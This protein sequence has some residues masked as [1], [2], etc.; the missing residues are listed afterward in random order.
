MA[1]KNV[2]ILLKLE[3]KFTKP[4]KNASKE[5][6][7]QH[8][9]MM[10]LNSGVYSFSR[11]VRSGFTSALGHVARFG[12]AL[13]GIG[14]ILSVAGIKS[15]CEDAIEGFNAA[16]EAETKLEAVLGNVPSII[17]QGEGAAAAAKD[18]LVAYA[19]QLEEVGVVAGDVTTAGLQQ[20]ATF[21]LTEDSLKKLM[22]GMA[23]LIA[24][25]KGINATQ[26]DA[27]G[28]A[29]LMGKAMSGQTGALTR[30]GII[31]TEHQA[32]VMKTGNEMERA[33]M[34]AEILEANVGGVNEA[35]AQT[36][37]GKIVQAQNLLGRAQDEIGGKLMSLKAEIYGFAAQ[38]IPA[39]Q[40]AAM[41]LIDM[42]TPKIKAAMQWIADHT[43]DIKAGL[44][45][46]KEGVATAWG[47]IQP[48]LGFAI[49][50]AN[51]LIPAILGVVGAISGV[52]V[53]A[54]VATKV[55]GLVK[56]FQDMRKVVKD[57]GGMLA[58]LKTGPIALI[59]LGIAAA[60]AAVIYLWNHCEGFRNF[61]KKAAAVIV[62]AWNKIKDTAVKVKD[63]A[64]AAFNTLKTTVSNIFNG[65]KSAIG[66]VMDWIEDKIQ[67]V[68]D[69]IDAIKQA[70]RDLTSGPW[71]NNSGGGDSY[72][73]R[74]HATGT[75][76]FSGGLTSINEGGRG[77][78]VNLPSGTQ[79]IPH[80]VSEKAVG[81]NVYNFNFSIQGNVI[82]N[83]Q[84]MEET[85][86]FITGR[87]KTALATV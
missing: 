30:A 40:N 23:N 70:W 14:G 58:W 49:K 51:T 27:I 6:K 75:P 12:A 82:G 54:D 86:R 59:I 9:A 53:V 38:Y 3:D 4:M 66:K 55:G 33:A 71:V 52:S 13:T 8:K 78:I 46:I 76:Y 36:D 62:A 64:V 72:D 37:A 56:K 31:M 44:L 69:A 35:L 21:Q 26:E 24:Q 67:K 41:K 25:Q 83:R 61:V 10:K 28:F 17:A 57:A 50:H 15:F 39:L 81:G 77:E 80:D 65:I 32:Q 84:Y 16:T 43:E 34:L 73:L 29:N 47:Y 45:R 87:I 48:V 63:G 20:L 5:V 74:G 42:V 60:V 11:N 22:P 85:A 1:N 68:K 18:R 19:D 7:A 2:N 79:I